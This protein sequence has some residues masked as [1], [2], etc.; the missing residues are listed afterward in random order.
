MSPSLWIGSRNPDQITFNFK[1]LF[2][3]TKIEETMDNEIICDTLI[4]EPN[5]LDE[6]DPEF[7]DVKFS[8]YYIGPKVR[9]SFL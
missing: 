7:K 4:H 2:E 5:I 6:N 3:S 9:F 8:S 1:C